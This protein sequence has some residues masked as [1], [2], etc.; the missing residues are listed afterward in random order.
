VPS[1]LL[2]IFPMWVM[3]YAYLIFDFIA[4]IL[5]KNASFEAPYRI[6][7]SISLFVILN[8][9]G[10]KIVNLRHQILGVVRSCSFDLSFAICSSI[11]Y[12]V[13]TQ[14]IVDS[15]VSEMNLHKINRSYAR[16]MWIFR[17]RLFRPRSVLVCFLCL[18]QSTWRIEVDM[19]NARFIIVP[20]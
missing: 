19:I 13:S 18:S 1:F 17:S 20:R 3:C 14:C 9:Y 7:L 10:I 16:G 15:A 2:F 6:V 5:L 4:L 12:S 8:L 11:Q